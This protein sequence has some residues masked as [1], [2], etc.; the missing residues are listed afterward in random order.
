MNA[1]TSNLLPHIETFD[2]A[3]FPTLYTPRL[4]LRQLRLDDA[5][6]ILRIRGDFEVT[7]YNIGSAYHSREQA[8]NL[9]EGIADGYSQHLEIRWGITLRPTDEVI[10]MVG[11]NYWVRHDHRASV[12][13]DLARA[14]WG[15]GIMTEALGTV[16]TFGFEQ[17]ALNRIEA[18]ADLRN[19]ASARVLEKVGFTRE[20]IQREQFFEEGSFHDLGLFSLLRRDFNK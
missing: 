3:A 19:P 4:I 10:G 7:R 12:G 1:D 14:Y 16:V 13:Y 20:G 8:I 15:Q 2:F 9:I 18:D 6:A 17:M 11:Y 5:D